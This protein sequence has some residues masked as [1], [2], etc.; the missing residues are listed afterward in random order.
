MKMTVKEF[1]KLDLTSLMQVNGG[2]SACGNYTQTQPANPP[3]G[4]NDSSSNNGGNTGG[5]GNN[6][7]DTPSSY[8]PSYGST[9]SS[10]TGTCGGTKTPTPPPEN[11]PASGDNPAKD[12]LN[13][14]N[15]ISPNNGTSNN[16]TG[17]CSSLNGGNGNGD[18]LKGKEDDDL[19]ANDLPANDLPENKT[20]APEQPITPETP[21]E[22]STP[23][24]NP[25]GGSTGNTPSNLNTK[26]D[27]TSKMLKSISENKDKKY[28][29][30]ENSATDYRCDDWVQ[31]VLTDAGYNYNDYYAGA[32]NTTN[33]ETHI[34]KLKEKG[35][36]T[37]SV[38]TKAGVYVVLMNDGKSYTKSN[39]ETGY[40]EA[41]TGLLVVQESGSYFIDNSSGNKNKGVEE[42]YSKDGS[43]SASSVMNRFL[44]DSF[45][46]QEIK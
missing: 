36:Y 16:S 34:S 39:G 10:S 22:P 18:E 11:P 44:Y 14:G 28:I 25:S 29:T 9:T 35:G 6:N 15:N 38:P 37:T 24:S 1:V 8:T 13:N 31:E 43:G 3:S 42:T 46:Y 41:H 20:P 32:A 26:N 4:G 19:P 5:S 40:Y 17:G 45:Y 12:D 27:A 30:T 2:T 21:T 7:G 33:C 23:P